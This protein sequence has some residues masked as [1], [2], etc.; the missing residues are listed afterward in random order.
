MYNKQ[1]NII[2]VHKTGSLWGESD[3]I[4]R[5]TFGLTGSEDGITVSIPELEVRFGRPEPG[6]FT[7]YSE[8]TEGKVISWITGSHP[9]D[10]FDLELKA[11]IE[12]ER[13]NIISGSSL[14]WNN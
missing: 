11:K 12:K 9:E 1:Y 10:L 3:V 13:D 7:T 8:L 2:N 14:P 5:V 6:T 4:R